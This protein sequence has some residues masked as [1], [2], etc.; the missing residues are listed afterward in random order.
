MECPDA[1]VSLGVLLLAGWASRPSVNH[2]PGGLT[3]WTGLK[4]ILPTHGKLAIRG[5]RWN[6]EPRPDSERSGVR[7]QLGTSQFLINVVVCR[8]S[9]SRGCSRTGS[10]VDDSLERYRAYL[11]LL[12]RLQ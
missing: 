11:G 6:N 7:E 8:R 9:V 1:S 5:D 3:L 4:P 10:A 12:A 2:V